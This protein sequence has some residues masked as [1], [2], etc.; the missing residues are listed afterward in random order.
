[1]KPILFVLDDERDAAERLGHDLERRYGADYDVAI[2]TTPSEGLAKLNELNRTGA[3]VALIIADQWMP[4]ML[5]TEF[6][7]KAHEIHPDAGRL[8]VIDVGDVSAEGAIVRALTLNQLDFYFG[9]PWASPEE[10][11]YPVTGEA[12]HVWALK[13]LPRYEKLRLVAPRESVAAREMRDLAE[14]NSV[15]TGF[16][17]LESAEGRAL[18]DRYAPEADRFPVLI[19]YDERVLI[20]PPNTEVARALG[21]ATEPEDK[22]YD[23][24]IVGAGPAGLAAGV[25]AASEGLS[26]AVI[27]PWV[28]GGQASMSSMIR[29]Y[30]G[31]PWGIGG[32][33]LM[34]R[35]E[36]QATGFG[37]NFVIA[38]DAIGL[39][40]QGEDRVVTLS[41]RKE[42]TSRTIVISTGV[43]YR[44]LDVPGLDS[45]I[46]AGVFYGATLS[47]A[48]A[49]GGLPVHILGGGNSAGQAAVQLAKA[50]AQVTILVRG[51]SLTKRMSNYL[52]RE[53]E[54]DGRIRV[55]LNTRIA[56][57][58][59]NQ[60]LEGLLL[61]DSA[62]DKT[63]EVPAAALYIFIGAAPRTDWVHQQIACDEPG[64]IL[65]GRDIMRASTSATGEGSG[66]QPLLLETSMPGVFAAGDVRHGSAKRVAAAVGEGST[67]VLLIQQYLNDHR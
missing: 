51:D 44:R 45:F 7:V 42:I 52:V 23:I 4:E 5:G 13:N 46:G 14:R 12:L 41:H 53:I 55:R 9:K 65:T 21:A 61:H 2:V 32:S 8:L 57:A 54:A 28:V 67:A 58:V 33:D 64:F 30:L 19:L 47:E 6:L 38:R 50:G 18:L 16:Y 49:L 39:R 36:R 20:D 59:G 1:M 40:A 62:E 37:A 11:L 27:E 25:Y 56:G 35:A 29:N 43:S 63:E 10:E 15:A 66:R 17:P 26:A 60:R 48:R 3:Q 22:L 31:F 24:T 34:E